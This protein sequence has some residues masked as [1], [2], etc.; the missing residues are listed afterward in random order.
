[1]LATFKAI[2]EKLPKS[3]LKFLKYIPDKVLFGNSYK[4]Y[5]PKVSFDKSLIDQNILDVLNYSRENTAFG[6]ETIPKKIYL[7]EAKQ[8]LSELPLIS[9][10]DL[11]DNLDHFT[12]REFQRTNAYLTTTGGSGRNPTTIL[13]S[14]ES[15]GIEW[16]HIHHAWALAGYKK[17]KDLKLT[18]RGKSLMGNKL[19]EYNPI[20]NELV[21]DTFK[22]KD[23]NFIEF[24][25]E[26]K[27][28]NIQYIHGYPSLLKEFIVYFRKYDYV[29]KIKGIFLGSEGAST[30]DKKNFSEFFNAK[31]IHW[32]GQSE[33]VALAVDVDA[34]DMFRV[35]TSY[36]YPRVVDGELIST[37][38]VNRALPLINYKMGDG[39][40]IIEDEE[41]I[42]IKN[43]ESRRGKDFVYLNK[44]KKVSTTAINLH[45]L[46]QNEILYYQIHQKEFGKIEIRILPKVS[47]KMTY[48]ELLTTFTDEMKEK[49]KD[50]RIETKIVSDREIVRS[51]RGKMILLVQEI[52]MMEK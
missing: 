52:K 51:H 37:S 46:V 21:V 31:V 7:D 26:I 13:L 5:L 43:I 3:Q 30:E 27:K 11:S 50:F 23:S 14:D 15:F 10:A 41:S 42:Y 32:Y 45:S 9:S 6:H 40:E 20:Y 16:A 25:K 2:Y 38:F 22:V 17:S 28:Y 18:L 39:A 34:N 24:L 35:Y 4:I 48:T 47:S 29:P 19:V 1:M 8:V 12:S 33:K 44:D 49:L 36:G